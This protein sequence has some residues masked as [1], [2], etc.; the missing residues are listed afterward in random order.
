MPITPYEYALLCSMSSYRASDIWSELEK[1]VQDKQK[2]R[3]KTLLHLGWHPLPTSEE[4][5][6]ESHHGYFGVAYWHQSHDGRV[7][8]VFAHRGTCFS[9][10]KVG[11]VLADIAIAAEQ[12]PAILEET[13]RYIGY[14]NKKISKWPVIPTQ[15]THTGFSLGGFIAGAVTALTD[16]QDVRAVT[17]DAPGVDYLPDKH[18]SAPRRIR[19]FVSHPNLVNT[20]NQHVGSV[21]HIPLSRPSAP[22]SHDFTLDLQDLGLMGP[23][24]LPRRHNSRQLQT[25][26][27]QSERH[28]DKSKATLKATQRLVETCDSHD[29]ER[30]IKYMEYNDDHTLH[31]AKPVYHWPT[32]QNE[33][34]YGP[35]EKSDIQMISTPTAWGPTVGLIMNLFVAVLQTAKSVATG[36]LWELTKKT[37]ETGRTVGLTGIRHSCYDHV[38]YTREAYW[39]A[40]AEQQAPIA[41]PTHGLTTQR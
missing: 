7:E 11:N 32:A 16:K 27:S 6:G 36:L 35:R 9:L 5:S 20:C 3:E 2:K 25:W 28:S 19:N 23:K 22:K 29:L 1:D 24:N 15:I 14:I 12:T 33:L 8:L 13:A 37:D 40:Q 34:I 18:H 26:L 17:F 41:R 4:Y 30:I 10:D 39:F 31:T 21:S 38:Y